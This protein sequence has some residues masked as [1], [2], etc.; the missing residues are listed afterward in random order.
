MLYKATGKYVEQK[1]VCRTENTCFRHRLKETMNVINI[2]AKSK[3]L[4]RGYVTSRYAN[5]RWGK[6]LQHCAN[7][8][9]R[10]GEKNF[11]KFHIIIMDK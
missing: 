6:K 9:V 8:S 10:R 4:Y 2:V 7:L 5:Q 1:T 3:L 11:S